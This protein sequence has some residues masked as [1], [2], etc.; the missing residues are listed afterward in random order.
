MQVR[1]STRVRVGRDAGADLNDLG[2]DLV[3]DDD[4]EARGD[5]SR[6]DVLDRKP[7]A[8]SE[9]TCDRFARSRD[10]VGRFGELE[11]LIGA[12]R[13]SALSVSSS[14]SNM[15]LRQHYPTT[16]ANMKFAALRNSVRLTPSECRNAAASRTSFSTPNS[17]M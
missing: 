7:R 2:R 15:T 13:T 8:A 5:A 12:L 4:G 11:R 10:R 3:P 6:L 1:S 17:F 9:D 16:S 14:Y